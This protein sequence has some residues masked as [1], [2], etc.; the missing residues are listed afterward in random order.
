MSIISATDNTFEKDV[1]KSIKPVIVEFC[2]PTKDNCKRIQA[3]LKEISSTMG[4][5]LIIASI[6]IESNPEV[7]K[8]Y[9]VSEIPTFLLFRNGEPKSARIGAMNQRKLEMWIEENV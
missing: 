4:S 3:A 2:A 9:G 8:K 6:N 1:L 7:T 5:K